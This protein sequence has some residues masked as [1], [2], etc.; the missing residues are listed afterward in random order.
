[1]KYDPNT[2]TL[3]DARRWAAVG[4]LEID[5]QDLTSLLA[6]VDHDWEQHEVDECDRISTNAIDVGYSQGYDEGHRI[7]R[8]VGY[9]Q[10]YEEGR[11]VQDND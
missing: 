7:G 8:C 3:E 11:H 1:M 9:D 6:D 5:P 4:I 10:G 2:T